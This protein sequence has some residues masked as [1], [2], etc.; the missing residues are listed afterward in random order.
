[1]SFFL[2]YLYKV[3]TQL[4]GNEKCPNFFLNFNLLIDQINI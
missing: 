3:Y 4:Y 1:M 2:V